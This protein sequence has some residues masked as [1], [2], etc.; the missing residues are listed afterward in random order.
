MLGHKNIM[1]T[2]VLVVNRSAP[3]DPGP[4]AAGTTGW[5]ESGALQAAVGYDG[6]GCEHLAELAEVRQVK[7]SGDAVVE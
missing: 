3:M 2:W 1:R 4:T 5:R 6:L 7:D